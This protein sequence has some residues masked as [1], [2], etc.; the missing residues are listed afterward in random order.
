L[1]RSSALGPFADGDITD[2]LLDLILKLPSLPTSEISRLAYAVDVALP[3][4][5]VRI[6]QHLEGTDPDSARGILRSFAISQ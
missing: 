5:L 2:I 1:K 4:A 6:V 3:E